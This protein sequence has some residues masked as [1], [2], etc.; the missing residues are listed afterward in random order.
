MELPSE[1]LSNFIQEFCGILFE[2]SVGWIWRILSEILWN[3]I[4]EFRRILFRNYVAFLSGNLLNSFQAFFFNLFQKICGVPFRNSVQLPSGILRV[5]LQEL[6]LMLLRN[7]V[8]FLSAILRTSFRYSA[9]LSS[10]VIQ[11]FCEIFFRNSLQ[12]RGIPSAILE[13]P[14]GI[15]WNSLQEL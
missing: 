14:S 4:E 3:S 6:C 8:E 12:L 13:F 5:C 15:M 2:N 1:I 7:C 10:G 11:K 9:E